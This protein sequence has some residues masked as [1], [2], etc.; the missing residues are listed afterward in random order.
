MT[1]ANHKTLMSSSFRRSVAAVTAVAFIALGVATANAKERNHMNP[2]AAIALGAFSAVVGGMIAAQRHHEHEAY[3]RRYEDDDDDTPEYRHRIVA[4]HDDDD[5]VSWC[6]QRY[7]SYSPQT[8][9]YTGY[10][11][12]QHYCEG[13]FD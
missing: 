7:R 3:E 1:L 13:P 5:H 8:D 9:T 10:D 11:G 4:V 12:R 2:G 6:M